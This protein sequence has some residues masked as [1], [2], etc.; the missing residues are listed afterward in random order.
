MAGW[1]PR[2]YATSAGSTAIAQRP[3]DEPFTSPAAAI[4]DGYRHY[5]ARA[6]RFE[7][8]SI[9]RAIGRPEAHRLAA[10]LLALPDRPTA[11]FAA[12]DTQAMGVLEAARNA[13]LRVPED[14]SVIGYDDIEIAEYLGLTTMSQKLYLSGQRG[15]E[16]LLAV[17]SGAPQPKCWR[18]I[19]RALTARLAG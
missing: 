1:R 6:F 9:D 13:S 18:S 12:S 11:I 3:L 15:V 4:A 16:L 19:N 5:R 17:L 8:T 14:L 2:C 10:E 7:R